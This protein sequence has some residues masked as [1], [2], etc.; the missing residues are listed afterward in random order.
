[1]DIFG[2]NAPLGVYLDIAD[3]IISDLEDLRRFIADSLEDTEWLRATQHAKKL[4]KE[5]EE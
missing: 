4:L 5:T 2:G 1:M 3:S